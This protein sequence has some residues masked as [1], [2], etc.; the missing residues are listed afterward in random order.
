MIISIDKRDEIIEFIVDNYERRA[1][2]HLQIYIIW[3]A[4]LIVIAWFVGQVSL[5]LAILPIIFALII[6]IAV[7]K[8]FINLITIGRTKIFIKKNDFI[9]N[10]NHYD[11]DKIKIN[12]GFISYHA[13]RM[14]FGFYH[15]EKVVLNIYNA[16]EL[17][18][19]FEMNPSD[20]DGF[21]DLLKNK[22]KFEPAS[23]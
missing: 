17:I 2:V 14:T 6:L 13:G 22:L 18:L 3:I 23:D 8:E 20:F 9:I 4:L 12:Y 1:M 5:L 15:G 11:I 21:K 10:D 16:K 7:G 19:S